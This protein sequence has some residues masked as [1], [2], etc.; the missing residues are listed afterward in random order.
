M[1]LNTDATGLQFRMLNASKGPSVRGPRAQC[2]KKAYQ[3]RLKATCERQERLDVKQGHIAEILVER[4]RVRGW[5]ALSL[6]YYIYLI[7]L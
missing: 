2:D 3:F 7:Q 4:G 1:G 6:E 5:S